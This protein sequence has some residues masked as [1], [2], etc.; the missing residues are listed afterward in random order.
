MVRLGREM[1]AVSL[2]TAVVAG[3]AAVAV[4]IWAA[5]YR[6]GQRARLLT[7][8]LPLQLSQQASRSDPHHPACV[9][10]P[11]TPGTPAVTPAATPEASGAEFAPGTIVRLGGLKSQTKLNGLL[12]RVDV[13]MAGSNR[14]NVR[15]IRDGKGLQVKSSN[16]SPVE[17]GADE[18]VALLSPPELCRLTLADHRALKPAHV[19]RLLELLRSESLAPLDAGRL[20]RCCCCYDWHVPCI[21]HSSTGEEHI[22]SFSTLD[23]SKGVVLCSNQARLEA[24]Q[25]RHTPAEGTAFVSR[26]T[27]GREVLTAE[28]LGGLTFV[29]LD[30]EE[31]ADAPPGGPRYTVLS[32]D[33]F[34]A[35]QHMGQALALEGGLAALQAACAA[36][37]SGAQLAR[38]GACHDFAN[39]T[40]FCF[41]A[42]ATP[43]SILPVTSMAS[44]DGTPEKARPYMLL[45]TCEMVLEHAR[46]KL[47]ELGAFPGGGSGPPAGAVPAKD[48]HTFYI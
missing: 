45:Y 17:A 39:H 31:G 10:A 32:S 6:A 1:L 33:H 5:L 8:P 7:A 21:R 9:T 47:V 46:P 41:N 20:L 18:L 23:T 11:A 12:A 38:L 37:R 4:A 15:A 34:P 24:L 35:L 13:F 27:A 42:S 22:F 14:Y 3:G 26:R 28:G 30:P 2:R 48:L 16:L 40:F 44:E 29:S 43:D 19:Q 36:G 25:G